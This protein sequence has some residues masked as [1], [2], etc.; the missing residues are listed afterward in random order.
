MNT[1]GLKALTALTLTFLTMLNL[2]GEASASRQTGILTTAGNTQQAL[3]KTQDKASVGIFRSAA[4]NSSNSYVVNTTLFS[5]SS[6]AASRVLMPA[7]SIRR[8]EETG[9]VY[10]MT[11][12]D[13]DNDKA[14]DIVL[15]TQTSETG[16]VILHPLISRGIQS[17]TMTPAVSVTGGSVSAIASGFFNADKNLDLAVTHL[18]TIAEDLQLSVFL[19]NGDGTFQAENRYSIG[20]NE[21]FPKALKVADFN[22]DGQNDLIAVTKG[23]AGVIRF[24]VRINDGNGRFPSRVDTESGIADFGGVSVGD[25]DSNGF[26]DDLV[27]LR[28]DSFNG[29]GVAELW[30]GNGDGSFELYQTRSY[31]GAPV[32]VVSGDYNN[33]DK[34]DFALIGYNDGYEGR[35][36]VYLNSVSGFPANPSS[37]NTVQLPCVV[38]QPCQAIAQGDFNQDTKT[39]LVVVGYYVNSVNLMLNDGS[40]AF[41]YLPGYFSEEAPVAVASAD[42]DANSSADVFV[43]N[44]SET[45]WAGVFLA[46]R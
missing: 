14:A 21:T 35:V 1:I 41:T 30:N 4:V 19:G 12:G 45:N 33:D 42:A 40:G 46:S 20:S 32:D 23:F 10:V 6:S 29:K 3:N 37:Q 31:P 24:I 11:V 43:A 27:V 8:P 13:F 28:F 26:A 9:R 34:S 2:T 38:A 17:F 7:Q 16:Q 22:R 25:F 18:G 5:A 15:G 44:F 36:L 39:D